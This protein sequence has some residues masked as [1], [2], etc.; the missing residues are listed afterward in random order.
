MILSNKRAEEIQ[1][2][3]MD[4][5]GDANFELCL[6]LIEKREIIQEQCR[7]I[8]EKLKV[9]KNAQSYQTV[10]QRDVNRPGIGVNVEFVHGGG[11][12]KG[13]KPQKVNNQN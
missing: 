8:E 5:V 2:E 11:G 9:E 6:Q 3:L 10:S 13:R 7:G 4:L 1:M 12:R